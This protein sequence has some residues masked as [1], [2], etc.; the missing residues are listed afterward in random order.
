MRELSKVFPDIDPVI[1]LSERFARDA[2]DVEWIGELAGNGPW[3]VISIDKFKKQ[4]GAEREA[5][6][7]AGLTV[8]VLDPQ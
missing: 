3:C 4:R 6:N 8:F 1:H 5:I 7:N 2:P